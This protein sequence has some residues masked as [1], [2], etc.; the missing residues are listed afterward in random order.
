MEAV[1]YVARFYR[2]KPAAAAGKARTGAGED[3]PQSAKPWLRELQ[4][5]VQDFRHEVHGKMA[6]PFDDKVLGGHAAKQQ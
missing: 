3:K 6:Y 4:A 5:S 1:V 2:D